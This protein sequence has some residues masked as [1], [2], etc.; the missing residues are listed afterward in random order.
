MDVLSGGNK[1][2]ITV[3]FTNVSVELQYSSHPTSVSIRKLIPGSLALS[4]YQICMTSFYAILT[5]NYD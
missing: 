3:I 2:K 5:I 1:N 4:P